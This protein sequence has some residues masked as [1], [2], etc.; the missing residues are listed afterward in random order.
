[1]ITVF[2]IGGAGDQPAAQ[3]A[4]EKEAAVLVTIA[5]GSPAKDA[6]VMMSLSGRSSA[7]IRY[8]EC[9]GEGQNDTACIV[10]AKGAYTAFNGVAPIQNNV[11]GSPALGD[12]DP[13]KVAM[14]A[15]DWA[16]AQDGVVDLGKGLM[17]GA[18]TMLVKH[19]K[20]HIVVQYAVSSSAIDLPSTVAEVTGAVV[21][22]SS[23]AKVSNCTKYAVD[24]TA[25]TSAIRCDVDMPGS[26]DAEILVMTTKL[27]STKIPSKTTRRV[28]IVSGDV[29]AGQVI[30]ECP[31]TGCGTGADTLAVNSAAAV[32]TIITQSMSFAS[33]TAAQYTGNLKS[34]IEVSS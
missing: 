18:T 24:V 8:A 9:M 21:A 28:G 6:A 2:L 1:M 14:V 13:E 17:A 10:L 23:S 32:K 11:Q 26:T 30:S 33:I 19:S 29:T 7:S 16:A 3:A 4:C 20:V 5:A 34:V 31:T 25:M 22:A 15:A 12:V 27:A